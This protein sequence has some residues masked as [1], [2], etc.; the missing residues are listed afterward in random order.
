MT[1][2]LHD[3]LPIS[4]DVVFQGDD[5]LSTQRMNLLLN[6]DGYRV[7]SSKLEGNAHLIAISNLAFADRPPYLLIGRPGHLEE[8]LE[9]HLKEKT[10]VPFLRE[11]V[12]WIAEQLTTRG[13]AHAVSVVGEHWALERYA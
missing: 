10:P 2:S 5:M 1:L 4:F 7:I 12:P 6:R 9:R 13:Y 3:A 8:A 11:W